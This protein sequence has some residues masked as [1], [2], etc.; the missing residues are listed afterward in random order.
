MKHGHRTGARRDHLSVREADPPALILTE[1][2]IAD[3]P[4]RRLVLA[5][6]RMDLS[7]DLRR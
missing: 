1:E 3:S 4:V 5:P 2:L 7:G 6:V